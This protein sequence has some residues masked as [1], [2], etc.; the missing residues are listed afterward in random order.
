MAAEHAYDLN[1]SY[2]YGGS[3]APQRIPV[4]QERE[5]V[6]LRRVPQPKRSR[7]QQLQLERQSHR[8]AARLFAFMALAV[9]MF[10]LFCNSMVA[11]TTSRANLDRVSAELNRQQELSVILN[12]DLS[13]LVTADNVDEIA[14]SLGLVKVQSGS[15]VYLNMHMENHVRVSQGK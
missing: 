4:P 13:N 6:E 8:K 1:Y 7:A 11:K 2:Q 12:R 9:V 3:A 14:S 5:R 15:E 10:G